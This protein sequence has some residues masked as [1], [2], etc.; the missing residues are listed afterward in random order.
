MRRD[1]IQCDVI[2]SPHKINVSEANLDPSNCTIFFIYFTQFNL[3][4]PRR[5]YL[6]SCDPITWYQIPA[7]VFRKCAA[8]LFI[9]TLIFLPH[10]QL[11]FTQAILFTLAI[12]YPVK[13]NNLWNDQ[14]FTVESSTRFVSL[15]RPQLFSFFGLREAKVEV[16]PKNG[17]AAIS[18]MWMNKL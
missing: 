12:E 5:Y 16:S 13:K 4:V 6:V 15:A 1:V 17:K 18:W 14:D 10:C 3:L 7:T 2:Q 9:A 8:T 11:S